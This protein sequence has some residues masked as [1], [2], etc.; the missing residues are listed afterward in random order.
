MLQY[1]PLYRMIYSIT[2]RNDC[3]NLG[4]TAAHSVMGGDYTEDGGT[5]PPKILL[6]ER[7]RKRPPT[8]ATFTKQRLDLFPF[9]L[10]Y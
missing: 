9:W 7:K 3:L 2:A 5:R 10:L 8:I 6:G 4:P 1:F